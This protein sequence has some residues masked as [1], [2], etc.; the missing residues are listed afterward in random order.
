MYLCRV[1]LLV[2]GAVLALSQVDQI[3]EVV[4]VDLLDLGTVPMGNRALAHLLI[5]Y[6]F[7]FCLSWSSMYWSHYA[8]R[9]RYIPGPTESWLSTA[10]VLVLPP[11]VGLMPWAGVFF[12]IR[13]A[14]LGLPNDALLYAQICAV[15]SVGVGMGCVVIFY[16]KKVPASINLPG[17]AH[18][19]TRET[20]GYD[21]SAVMGSTLLLSFWL[22][23]PNPPKM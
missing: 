4:R 15:L 17:N 5:N 8:L 12:A 21:Q 1:P 6:F 11:I 20:V 7:L 10:A 23:L 18:E 14:T 3:H 19:P 13:Q 16:V 9:S 2:C 22:I